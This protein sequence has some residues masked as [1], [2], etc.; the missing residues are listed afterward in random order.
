MEFEPM[1]QPFDEDFEESISFREALE[2]YLRHIKWFILSVLVF[3][4]FAFLKLRYEVPN[5]NINASIL[6]KEQEKGSSFSDLSSFENLGLFGSNDES[7]ENEIQIIKSRTLMTKVVNELKL[8]IRYYIKNSPYNL[9]QYPNFPII[10][11]FKSDSSK[12]INNIATNFK[13][14]IKSE[15]EFEFIDFD[16]VSIGNKIFGKDFKAN[17]GNEEM[18]NNRLIS[19]ELNKNFDTNIIGETIL[20]KIS[21]IKS[22]VTDYMERI[23]IEPVNEKLSKV[24]T[25]SID[26]AIKEKGIALINNLIEQYNADGIN[27]NN[28]VA[29]TTTDFLNE[30]IE[31][32][33]TELIAIEGAAQQ[34]KTSKGMI[35]GAGG[36]GIVLESSSINES[37]LVNANTQL[38]LANMMY[39]QLGKT[40]SSESLPSNI[41]L[42]DPGVA[43]LTSEYNNTVLKRKRIL[44]SSSVKNPIIV[45][46]DS[47]LDVLR[48][49][50]KSSLSAFQS[51]SRIQVD[52]LNGQRGRISGRI[53]AVPKHEKE[54][55]SIVREQETKNQL[56]MFLLNKREESIISNSINVDKAKIIDVA[57]SNGEKVSPKKLM[58]YIGSIILGLLIPFLVIYIKNMLD[59]K[60]HDEKDIRKLKIPYIGDVP[61][62]NV[63]K[64]VFLKDGDNSN[65]AE[66]FR[67]IR[68]N[69]N[70]MLDSKEMGKTVFVTST[71]SNEGKTFT[72]INLA[73][74]LA[75]SGKKTLLLGMDLRAPK[76]TKYLDLEDILGVTNYISNPDLTLDEVTEK[77]TKFKNLHLINSGDIPPNPVELLMSKRVKQLF[78]EIK[79]K[80]EYIIVDTAPVGMVTDT[81][82][83]SQFADLTIYVVKANFLDKRMLH[84]PER[85]HKENKLPN[86]AVLINGS[87]HSK[88]AYGYG[89]G[90]G[91]GNKKKPWYKKK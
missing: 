36:A 80:Y 33:S 76:I 91:Y 62:T 2:K 16:K 79:L 59:T 35:G 69:L 48:S 42:S 27:D 19:I 45:G 60:I 7:L 44:K 67:Y 52:V 83:M 39:N 53:A 18:S 57:Y 41:G 90:Y 11:H 66:A 14:F 65:I 12:S 58:V 17:L 40:G 68:T 24:L 37:Q 34:F 4:I 73:S 38:R 71:Q 32:I 10:V 64:D 8:N 78:E 21:P 82:Q 88:G 13:I 87:D 50:L 61:L 28:L 20:V 25:L 15:K 23:A 54:Y 30:R 84:I 26:E 46:I 49:N 29:K 86:M 81:I 74:S 55:K 75:V 31:L 51:S 43:A 47:Q 56:Y 70:F 5:Y 9:E 85:L 6:I 63:K 89:Y 77:Y 22:I 3:G 1:N 72:A